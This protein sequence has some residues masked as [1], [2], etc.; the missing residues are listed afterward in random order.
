MKQSRIGKLIFGSESFFKRFL[1]KILR[2][3]FENSD[4][5]GTDF[6]ILIQGIPSLLPHSHGSVADKVFTERPKIINIPII[7]ISI[8]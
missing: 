1:K 7:L 6:V 8:Y 5:L 2:P 4:V 3:N